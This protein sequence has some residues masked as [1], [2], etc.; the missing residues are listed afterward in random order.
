MKFSKEEKEIIKILV[1]YNNKATNI[2]M[3]FNDT[4][5]LE[6]RG[7]GIV[8]A[9]GENLIFF[10]KKLYPDFF[11]GD[12]SPY[13]SM[14]FSLLE[15][16]IE[17]R[18]L[19]LGNSINSAPLVIGALSSRWE[20]PNVLVVNESEVIVLEG[21]YKGWYGADGRA[22]YNWDKDRS[23]RLIKLSHY[24]HSSYCVSEELKE[25]VKNDFKTDE[26]IRFAKQ[27]FATWISIGVAILLGI[28]GIIF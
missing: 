10:S 20:R 22:M 21:P 1:N 26:E 12:D 25:L 17:N 15:K 24:L 28:L 4:R 5:L 7:L 18:F 2:A 13:I 23:G 27:Q 3:A 14:L 11:A 9:G 16:L 6:K 8:N 19:I